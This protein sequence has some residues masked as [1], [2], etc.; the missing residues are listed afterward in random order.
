MIMNKTIVRGAFAR[1][2]PAGALA[3]F[4]TALVVASWP[5]AA[6]EIE[7]RIARGGMLYDRWYKITSGDMPR[8]THPVYKDTKGKMKRANTWRCRECHGPDYLG[9]D[10]FYAKGKRKT[11][12]KGIR[13]FDGED[14]AKVVAILSDDNHRYTDGMFTAEDKEDL[15]LFVTKGQVDMAAAIDAGSKAVKTA[16]MEKGKGY[17]NT[18]CGGCHGLD[19]QK[20]TDM[21]AMGKVANRDPW[22]TLH[23]IRNGQP[24]ET[25][26][27]LRALDP[28]ISVDILAYSMTLPK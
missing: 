23:K 21:P 28:Q 26:P 9:K 19:G 5:V 24:G 18:L 3:V 12:I 4:V 10:G 17:Y 15:A 20:I 2:I 27:A 11:G 8:G 16:D 14:P 25:M 6:D 13:D 1:L 7:S 22:T